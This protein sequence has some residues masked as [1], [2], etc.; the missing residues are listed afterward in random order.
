MRLLA[1]TLLSASLAFAQPQPP[2]ARIEGRV[3]STT[4]DPIPKATVSIVP[5]T[6]PGPVVY[7]RPKR[8]SAT[9]R[10]DGTFAVEDMAPGR[11]RYFATSDAYSPAATQPPTLTLVAGQHLEDLEITM[12]PMGALSGRVLDEDGNG[13]PDISV[14]AVHLGYKQER[15]VLTGTAAS[16]TTDVRGFYRFPHLPPGSYTVLAEIPRTPADTSAPE[17]YVDTIYPHALDP[18][19]AL[20][21]D[22]PSGAVRENIDIRLRKERV[23]ALR[24]KLVGPAGAPVAAARVRLQSRDGTYANAQ[25]V[26]ATTS[27]GGSFSFSRLLPGDHLLYVSPPQQNLNGR[28]NVSIGKENVEGLTFP[29]VAATPLQGAVRDENGMPLA[30]DKPLSLTLLE[31]LGADIVPMVPSARVEDDGS[32]TIEGAAPSRFQINLTPPPGYY[33]QSIHFLGRDITH[34]LLD[35]TAGVPGPLEIVLSSKAAAIA[36]VVRNSRAETVPEV[37]VTLAD[38]WGGSHTARTDQYGA[39]HFSELAPGE[40]QLAAWDTENTGLLTNPN[41]RALFASQ[42]ETAKLSEG[43]QTSTELKL[44]SRERIAAARTRF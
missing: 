23:Y 31:P 26:Q 39:Y 30:S 32:F 37:T 15:R 27:P 41:F 38:P 7:T 2:P 11:Y 16:A 20:T 8:Y 34:D 3:L 28:L 17:A 19:E 1:T 33:L 21:V 24:G 4:G 29:L 6:P 44:I 9:T 35:L 14:D 18:R 25:P 43:E 5:A 22:L 40:Y 13:M 10:D 36:G 42:S 12:I